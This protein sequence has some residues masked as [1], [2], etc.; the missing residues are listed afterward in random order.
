MTQKVSFWWSGREARQRPAKPCTRVQI[1]SPPQRRTSPRR[2]RKRA[3][4]SV[5]ERYLDTVEA[6][7]S[8]P[9]S[10]T[11]E[12]EWCARSPSGLLAATPSSFDP[13]G[14]PRT[15]DVGGSAPHAPL[16]AQV[17]LSV[18][19]GA[20][21]CFFGA[22]PLTPR[23]ARVRVVLTGA[24]QLRSS[25]R[26][27]PCFPGLRPS[28]RLRSS[29]R[30]ASRELLFFGLRP[31]SPAGSGSCGGGGVC[32]DWSVSLLWRR[33]GVG[34][35]LGE[36]GAFLGGVLVVGVRCRRRCRRRRGPGRR[37]R[38]RPRGPGPGRRRGRCRCRPRS[39]RRSRSGRR[40]RCS[41]GRTS[42]LAS[43]PRR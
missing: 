32:A 35:W 1:P 31:S 12:W 41:S 18:P 11:S 28:P 21:V 33:V 22:P 34:P 4:S 25:F 30:A 8:I 5:G 15:P 24:S 2:P 13:G 27:G 19:G 23:P 7:G 37:C 42:G 29:F 3:I 40:R 17:S 38:S 20:G 43:C 10:P 16:P 14:D 6:T 26:A 9:V 39:R 36:L